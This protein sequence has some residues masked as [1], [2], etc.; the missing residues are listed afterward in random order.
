MTTDEDVDKLLAPGGALEAV[1]KYREQG[2]VKAIGFSAHDEA[3][4]LRLI[5]TE[6]FDTVMF[7]LNFYSHTVGG[8]GHDVL[9]EAKSRGMG[10]FALKS[11][12]RCRLEP[13]GEGSDRAAATTS[14]RGFD[15]P[16]YHVWYQPETEPEYVQKLLRYTLSIGAHSCLSPGALDLFDIMSS[17][18]QGKTMDELGPLS[19]A[20]EIELAERYEGLVPVFHVG[21]HGGAN[22]HSNWP[23]ELPKRPP[24]QR[25]LSRTLRQRPLPL[26]RVCSRSECACARGDPQV[27]TAARANGHR[28]DDSKQAPVPMHC[29]TDERGWRPRARRFAAS[30]DGPG[31]PRSLRS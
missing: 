7:P 27:T 10:I 22:M 25:P 4:A 15:H 24:R 26:N 1:K 2:K 3:A 17:I 13:H 31:R 11:M 8:V 20:E 30:A 28:C 6:E 19:E 12:A 14:E 18:A 5:K 23:N 16:E 29:V 21:N 9:T